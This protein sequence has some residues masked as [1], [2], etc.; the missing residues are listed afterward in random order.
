[1]NT[2]R[3]TGE[4]FLVFDELVRAA[5]YRGTV[6]YQELAEMTGLPTSG[7]FMGVELGHILREVSEDQ[8]KLG[9]PMLSAIAINVGG[10]P[11]GGFLTLARELGRLTATGEEEER[12]FWEQEKSAVY[13]VWRRKFTSYATARP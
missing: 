3:G 10:E 4:Y 7:A 1:V 11:G 2:Y 8:L 12:K 6:T 5:R 13:D 9:K